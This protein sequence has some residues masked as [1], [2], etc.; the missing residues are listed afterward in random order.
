[1]ILEK[2]YKLRLCYDIIKTNIDYTFFREALGH[3]TMIDFFLCS[4]SLKSKLLDHVILDN[5]INYSDHLPL[6]LGVHVDINDADVN[7]IPPP[8]SSKVS[9]KRLRWDHAHLNTYYDYT[10]TVCLPLLHSIEACLHDL[11]NE[12]ENIASHCDGVYRSQINTLI[13]NVQAVIE[14]VY[15]GIVT[16]L[17][18]A[19]A[20]CI[21]ALSP[22]SL[23]HWWTE[24]LNV[25][26]KEAQSAFI[27]WRA[28]DKPA[29]GMLF[30]NYI[31]AKKAFRGAIK[32]QKKE[33]KK[34]VNSALIQALNSTTDFWGLW[35]SKLGKKKKLPPVWGAPL[36]KVQ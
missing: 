33:S 26:K 2:K 16:S 35:K 11:Q 18:E 32:K 31:S 17:A 25:Y 5:V 15:N 20:A 9:E 19:A 28:A 36:V 24:E 27:R 6:C 7:I 8:P 12:N 14:T 30:D 21:P 34:S 3:K 1:M 10:Y 4:D 22:Q 29:I 13:P 23:K